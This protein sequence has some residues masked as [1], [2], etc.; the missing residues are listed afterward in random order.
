MNRLRD[1]I[2]CACLA[3]SNLC[4]AISGAVAADTTVSS[5]YNPS[6]ERPGLFDGPGTPIQRKKRTLAFRY[7]N[8]SSGPAQ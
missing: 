3:S 6:L 8:Y 4:L 1:A 2:L 7:P 5:S